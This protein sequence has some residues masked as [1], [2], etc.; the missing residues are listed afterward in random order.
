[1]WKYIPYS[2]S[3]LRCLTSFSLTALNI[4]PLVHSGIV[5]RVA[6]A[7]IMNEHVV[8]QHVSIR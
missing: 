2:I 3:Q 1:M 8:L 4:T 7:V 5:F 6:T